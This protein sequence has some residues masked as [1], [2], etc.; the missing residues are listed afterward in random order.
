[1]WKPLKW[2]FEWERRFFHLHILFKTTPSRL[3]VNLQLVTHFQTFLGDLEEQI[4]YDNFNFLV[5]SM[6]CKNIDHKYQETK[7][8]GHKYRSTSPKIQKVIFSSTVFLPSS[9]NSFFKRQRNLLFS[10]SEFSQT[11]LCLVD[12]KEHKIFKM[13]FK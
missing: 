2:I 3:C 8:L 7:F 1:M 6:V 4:I 13:K 9:R 5:L 12:N 10:A 11:K